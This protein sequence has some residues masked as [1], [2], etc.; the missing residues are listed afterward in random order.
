MAGGIRFRPFLPKGLAM[1]G[2]KP[3]VR[4]KYDNPEGF[5]EINESD[6]DSSKHKI[7]NA[8]EHDDEMRRLALAEWAE[9]VA[10]LAT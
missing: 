5:C 4:I 3:V 2:S 7:F 9:A 8:V 6:F 1:F 10:A